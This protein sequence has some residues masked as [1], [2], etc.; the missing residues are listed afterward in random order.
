[1]NYPVLLLGNKSDLPVEERIIVESK[2]ASLAAS[3]K[4]ARFM[5]ASAKDNLNVQEA[6]LTLTQDIMAVKG[7][8]SELD[9]R[10][11]KKKRKNSVK[12]KKKK[13]S[14]FHCSIM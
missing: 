10:Q 8:H 14:R 2:A 12:K 7:Q 5:E 1:M 6:F 11:M 13:S 3:W 9:K 4:N